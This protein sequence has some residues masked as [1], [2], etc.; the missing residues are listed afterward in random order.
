MLLTKVK[1]FSDKKEING[2]PESEILSLKYQHLQLLIQTSQF[3]MGTWHK[4]LKSKYCYFFNIT[5]P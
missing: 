1:Q 3:Y 4:L 2:C 5:V